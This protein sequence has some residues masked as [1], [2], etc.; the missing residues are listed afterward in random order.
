MKIAITSQGEGLESMVDARF[1]RARGFIVYDDI[2]E[3]YYYIDNKQ[4]LS[5]MQGAGIQSAK[6]VIDR[7]VDVVITGNVGPKAFTTLHAAKVEIYSGSHG[8]VK[9][10]IGDF[11]SGKLVRTSTA[12]VEGHW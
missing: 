5:A 12:N 2:R 8:T 9:D 4:N 7:G 10:V 1:G 6:T 11:K 3:E